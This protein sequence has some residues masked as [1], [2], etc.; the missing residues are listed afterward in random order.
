MEYICNRLMVVGPKPLVKTFSRS[1][2][3]KILGAA[4]CQLAENSPGRSITEF[5]T[6]EA[7]ILEPLR[8]LSLRWTKLVFLLDWEWENKRLK[9]F[10]NAK[11][12]IVE[13]YR[14][15]Y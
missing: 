7:P 4:H 12:G 11:D 10:V 6:E 9:G 8:K 5:N 13:S 14:L 3:E 1:N 15:E 2:W